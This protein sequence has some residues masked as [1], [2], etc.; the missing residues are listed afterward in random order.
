MYREGPAVSLLRDN[1]MLFVRALVCAGICVFMTR[2][3][4]FS[5]FFLVP[6]GFSAVV[7]G[8]IV[9][10][11]AFAMA[12]FGNGFLTIAVSLGNGLGLA[13]VGM[14][15]LYFTVLAGG[16]TWMMAGNPPW[17][18]QSVIRRLFPGQEPLGFAVPSVPQVRTLFRFVAASVMATLMFLGTAYWLGLNDFA[19]FAPRIEP[20]LSA[21]ISSMAGGDAVRQSVLEHALTPERILETVMMLTLRGGALLSAVFLLFFSRKMAFLAARLFRKREAGAGDL[22]GFFVPPRAIWVLSLSLLMVFLGRTFSMQVIEVVAW[23]ALV[24]CGLM[25]LAQGG[26]V[27]LFHLARRPVP[28]LLRMLLGVLFVILVFSPGINFFVLGALLVLGIA[29]NWLPMR[30]AKQGSP[31]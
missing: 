29:E 19:E 16:F 20:L 5:L 22:A 27:V 28:W 31:S 1:R 7:Y 11:L 8:A 3:G 23:N 17:L 25:F 30:T 9:A 15:M 4:L 6:L 13:G 26:G 21:Y 2:V 14:D 12:A 24:M 18:R 10:W